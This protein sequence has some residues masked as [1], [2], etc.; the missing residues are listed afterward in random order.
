MKKIYIVITPFFP[1]VSSF[2]GAFIYDQVQALKRNSNYEVIVFKP[3]RICSKER[4]Y[5][6]K[7]IKVYLFS[8]IQMP[9][10]IF[11][12]L[13]N[14]INNLLFLKAIKKIGIRVD[15]IEIAHGHTARF[16]SF[17][18]ALKKINPHIRTVVQ[19]HD[20]D[21]FNIRNG[22]WAYIKWNAIYRAKKSIGLFDQIDCHICVSQFVAD[23]LLSFPHPPS[24]LYYNSYEQILQVVKKVHSARIKHLYVLYNGVDCTIFNLHKPSKKTLFTI[25]CVG[26]FVD[27]KGQDILIKAVEVLISN[28]VKV[29]VCFIGSGPTLSEC[30]KMVVE[31]GL[32]DY[33]E[34]KAEVHHHELVNF[35]KTLDLFVLPSYFEGFGC[36]FT[37]AAAC[38]IPFMVCKYQG[39]AEYISPVEENL[40]TFPAFDHQRLAQLIA[41][42]IK[43]TPQQ[44][45]CHPFD[46]DVLITEYLNYLKEI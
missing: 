21:P 45:L 3:K 28:H 12:G 20:P 31:K 27:W 32:S 36:V 11:N 24:H 38:G 37:E 30:K 13:S 23:S 41:Y 4:E 46:I 42:Y 25:G 44:H 1:S 35:Y 33:V 6:Y 7:G 2:R 22:K 5:T 19:H 17:P 43:H 34:F 29:H 14:D 18:L 15:D 10:Y 9:S 8:D 40:W 39:A 16:A 26:N